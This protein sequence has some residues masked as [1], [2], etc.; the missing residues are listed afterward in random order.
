[1]TGDDVDDFLV[2]GTR[3]IGYRPIQRFLFDLGNFFERQIRLAAIRRS[4]FLVAFDELTREPAEHVIGDAGCVADIWIFCKPAWLESLIRE[5][6]HE[7]LERHT[8]LE[9][10]RSERADSVHKPADG[11]AFL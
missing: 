2:A 11:A 6:F 1:M 9:R 4:R 3:Q 7:A 5:F 10:N 8:V